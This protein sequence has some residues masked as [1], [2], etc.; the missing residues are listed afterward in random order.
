MS[1]MIH[2]MIRVIDAA[3]SI[4]FYEKALGLK[5]AE[6]VDFES[7]ELIYLQGNDTS[8]EL[9]LTVN[10]GRAEPYQAG[11]G[12]GHLAV[13][14]DDLDAEHARLTNLGLAPDGINEMAHDGRPFARFF[15]LSDPDGYRI[16]VIHRQGRFV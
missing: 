12:Y 4:E 14:V 10:A 16:E 6:R 8:F 11:E 15:F 1:K 7:F 3:R 5:V 9:E 13:V 2:S